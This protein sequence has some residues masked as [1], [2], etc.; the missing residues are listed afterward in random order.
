MRVSSAWLLIGLSAILSE[1]LSAQVAPPSRFAVP[2]S[3][4]ASIGLADTTQRGERAPLPAGFVLEQTA[5][6]S[7]GFAA[8][9]LAGGLVGGVLATAGADRNG[10]GFE[11]LLGMIA[12]AVLAGPVGAAIAVDRFSRPRGIASS[13]WAA[14][15]GG[16][17]GWFGGPAFYVTVPLG[18][19]TAYN[20]ARR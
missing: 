4:P 12:G 13:I 9:A 2:A 16:Y 1:N 17:V 5:A 11:G 18:T 20:L 10:G 7:G 3:P 19:V 15:A 6:A 14:M 8:A